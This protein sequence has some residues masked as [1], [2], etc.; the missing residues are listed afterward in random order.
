MKRNQ[1]GASNMKEREIIKLHQNI[2]RELVNS[3]LTNGRMKNLI[4]NYI[5][6]VYLL[7]NI[8]E[9]MQQT[10]EDSITERRPVN[11]GIIN[12]SSEEEP[13][14]KL[15]SKGIIEHTLITLNKMAIDGLL[16]QDVDFDSSRKVDD[17]PCLILNYTVFYESFKKYCRDNNIDHDILSLKDFKRE[18]MKRD[19]CLY[20]NKP[21]SF[22]SGDDL[23]DFKTFRAAVLSLEKLKEWH[24]NIDYLVYG[25]V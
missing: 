13:E 10:F 22:R 18:L 19:Y 15:P 7:R 4:A 5:L 12:S 24:L 20:Y 3:S 23:K 1:K 25:V 2:S 16:I 9:E 14:F 8:F 6:A 17:E 11:E 21:V